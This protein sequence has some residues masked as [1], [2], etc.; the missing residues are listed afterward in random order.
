MAVRHQSITYSLMDCPM[1]SHCARSSHLQPSWCPT[2]FRFEIRPRI[3]DC[4]TSDGIFVERK[5]SHSEKHSAVVRC[6]TWDRVSPLLRNTV[7][8]TFGVRTSNTHQNQGS[9]PRFS[10]SSRR[11]SVVA[12]TS[13]ERHH[14]MRGSASSSETNSMKQ[15]K[16]SF[17]PAWVMTRLCTACPVWRV[18][19]S[20]RVC[21]PKSARLSFARFLSMRC[22]SGFNLLRDRV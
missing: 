22:L 15:K 14:S 8:L 3:S 12:T 20:M 16:F 2:W 19:T 18:S 6:K 9:W 11:L 17:G 13:Q 10:P 1:F 5:Q 21:T 7:N 4:N